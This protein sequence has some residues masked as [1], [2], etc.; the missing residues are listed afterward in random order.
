MIANREKTMSETSGVPSTAG[1][2]DR[3][4]R[5][6]FFGVL[7]ILLGLFCVLVLA[8]LL[9]ANALAPQFAETLNPRLM[10]FAALMYAGIA[11]MMIWLGVGSILC[12]RWAHALWLIVAWAWLL[13]GICM[14]GFYALFA[15]D[16]LKEAAGNPASLPG[17][18]FSVVFMV[19]LFIAVPGAMVLFYRSPHVTATCAARDPRIRWTEACPSPVLTLAVWLF[20]GTLSLLATPI[21]Y[22]SV[23]P[24]FGFLLSGTPATVVLLI[25]AAAGFYLAWGTYRLKAAAWWMTLAVFTFFSV[26][27]AITVLRVELTEFYRL[28][29]YT[30]EQIERIGNLKSFIGEAVAW[31]IAAFY[32]L[33][34]IYLIWIRKFF[35]KAEARAE[36]RSKV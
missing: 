11:A 22:G 31:W 14:L 8:G 12:R 10:G 18:I 30:G 34:L 15:R 19:V 4:N 35:R 24:W 29:G 23:M 28:A 17:V 33:S 32:F 36:S 26:S 3:R 7:E 9:I 13:T 21:A 25:C 20:L 2:K 27:A 16:V 1:Y 5:L 6:L